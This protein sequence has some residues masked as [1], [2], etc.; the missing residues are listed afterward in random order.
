MRAAKKSDH[1]LTTKLFQLQRSE[2]D[3]I[4]MIFMKILLVSALIRQTGVQILRKVLFFSD[5]KM[6]LVMATKASRIGSG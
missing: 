1:V 6:C 2:S 4:T 5:H 3:V